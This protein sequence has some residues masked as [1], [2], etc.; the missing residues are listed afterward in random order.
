VNYGYL[1]VHRTAEVAKAVVRTYYGKDG[2]YSY[3]VGVQTAVGRR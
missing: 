2:A 3:F 1:G